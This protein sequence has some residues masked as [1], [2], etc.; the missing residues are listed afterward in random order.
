M[1]PRPLVLVAIG[2]LLVVGAGAGPA[3]AD[4]ASDLAAA[5]SLSSVIKRQTDDWRFV[6][7]FASAIRQLDLRV[8]HLGYRHPAVAATHQAIAR[9]YH[10]S[11]NRSQALAQLE[12]TLDLRREVCGPRH[13]DV[14][15]TLIWL[16]RCR[17]NVFGRNDLGLLLTPLREAREIL[18]A[19][20][21]EDALPFAA[22]WQALGNVESYDHTKGLARYRRAVE[23]R[24]HHLGAN[25]RDL[26]ESRIWLA[27]QLHWSERPREAEETVRQALRSL[28]ASGHETDGAVITARRFLGG[29]LLARG[30]TDSAL[31]QLRI[32]DQEM[33]R[34]RPERP[35]DL[36]LLRAPASENLTFALLKL[37]REEEAWEAH[38]RELV[39]ISDC[40]A[41]MSRR[42]LL[43]GDERA[44]LSRLES[45]TLA[46]HAACE[47]AVRGGGVPDSLRCEFLRVESKRQ[48]LERELFARASASRE[49]GNVL[50]RVRKALA[51][52]QAL[53]GWLTPRWPPWSEAEQRRA[54]AW[55]VRREGPVRWV[56]LGTFRDRASCMS[57]RDLPRKASET[58]LAASK[59][60][61]R[62]R[63]DPE[64]E[65]IGRECRRRFVDPLLP[66]LTDVEEV[67][68][69]G[70][71]PG[72]M[73]IEWLEDERGERLVDRFAISYVSSPERFASL[74]EEVDAPA[75]PRRALVMGDPRCSAGVAGRT[76][77]E[78]AGVAPAL[79]LAVVR[80]A[81]EGDLSALDE[82]PPLPYSHREGTRV[83]AL[84]PESTLLLGG[85]AT[86]SA[87]RTLEDSGGLREFDV[88]HLATHALIDPVYP[89]RSCLALSRDPRDTGGGD[90]A[91]DA[92]DGIVTAREILRGWD[93]HADLVTLSGC[94]TAGQYG[95]YSEPIGFRQTLL[96]AGTRSLLVSLWDVDDAAT[97]LLMERFYRDYVGHDGKRGM[98]KTAA[99][100]E[101]KR[102][103]RT[104]TDGEGRRPFAHP[105]Y[106]SGFVLYG[107]PR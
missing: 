42:D 107:D 14:A 103:V 19:S 47:K 91:P 78:E 4:R 59:W 2:V 106:W 25:D 27:H 16:S 26:A 54:H 45:R 73:P 18:R 5:D 75:A 55:V 97:S 44:R 38:A 74:R 65:A 66:Y 96:R 12:Y 94:R 63:G 20:Y 69:A 79:E 104:R 36:G 93:L 77:L 48:L 39:W 95:R 72:R 101:A 34:R 9:I 68:V 71:P 30:K 70:A 81:L 3:R 7:A 61:T 102:W 13:P 51:L 35:I 41:S 92:P 46:L 43:G 33:A 76:P 58:I 98:S 29:R 50:P 57:F 28:L 90:L 89:L 84:F 15:E 8:R 21:P 83:A 86:E 105:V 24:R 17:K 62:V 80:R 87:V 23:I 60:P 37:G 82:L 85:Q 11:G 32:V 6:D 100:A 40:F 49:N 10:L 56:S 99:L 53:V 64:L 52:D 22:Y 1:I 88:V 67:V 31:V